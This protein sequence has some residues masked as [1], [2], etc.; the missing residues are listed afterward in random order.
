MTKRACWAVWVP[1]GT[2]APPEA[3]VA[4]KPISHTT[5][6][7]RHN[8]RGDRGDGMLSESKRDVERVEARKRSEFRMN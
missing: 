1:A 7:C 2:L 3:K 4:M 5:V 8:E 6:R